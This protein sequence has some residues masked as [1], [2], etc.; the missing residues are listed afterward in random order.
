MKGVLFSL[1][2][3]GL[4]SVEV[5]AIHCFDCNSFD[6]PGCSDPFNNSTSLMAVDCDAKRPFNVEFD[7]VATFCRKIRQ[8]SN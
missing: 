5:F 7:V 1:F 6:D 3:F 4:T 8:K 2:L